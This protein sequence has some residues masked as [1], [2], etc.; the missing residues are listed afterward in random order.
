MKDGS[1]HLAHKAEHAVDMER[2]DVSSCV[3]AIEEI[4]QCGSKAGIG[5]KGQP[6]AGI[7]EFMVM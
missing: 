5:N 7:A 3:D 6:G 2:S 4:R 1:T